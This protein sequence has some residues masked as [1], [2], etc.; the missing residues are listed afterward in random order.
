M[1]SAADWTLH[2]AWP[3]AQLLPC[4]QTNYAAADAA[5]VINVYSLVASFSPFSSMP[6]GIYRGKFDIVDTVNWATF[7]RQLGGKFYKIHAWRE[8]VY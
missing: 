1:T 2:V 6:L 5:P 3:L 7:R 4:I 8:N